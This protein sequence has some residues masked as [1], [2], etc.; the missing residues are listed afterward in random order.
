MTAAR[1][2]AI[3]DKGHLGWVELRRE[4]YRETWWLATHGW[5]R[6]DPSDAQRIAQLTSWRV[7]LFGHLNAGLAAAISGSVSRSTPV[8]ALVALFAVACLPSAITNISGALKATWDMT[9]RA[10]GAAP[11]DGVYT[12]RMERAD[13]NATTAAQNNQG[14]FTFNRNGTASSQAGL[15][16]GGFTNVSIT[17]SGR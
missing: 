5:V 11:V 15:A 9:A 3:R 6:A 12:I 14:T 17:Y 10:G 7:N 8:I 2:G 16:N 4:P 1:T 13:S